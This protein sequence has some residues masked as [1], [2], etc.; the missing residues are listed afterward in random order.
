MRFRFLH[1]VRYYSFVFIFVFV[2]WQGNWAKAAPTPKPLVPSTGGR[3]GVGAS[4]VDPFGF[5]LKFFLNPNNALQGDFGWAPL[6]HGHGRVGADYLWH[7]GTLAVN[8]TAALVGYLG[9]G[10]ALAFWGPRG[11]FHGRGQIRAGLLFR[12]PILGLAVHWSD[13]P[14]DT[15]FEGSWSPYLAPVD[16]RHGD[17][18][19]KARWYF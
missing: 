7:P 5:T 15:C 13:I 19:I 3:A 4:V 17:F 8:S 14:L 10:S 2:V 12:L 9:I 18:S 11:D 1:D 16:V 6:H